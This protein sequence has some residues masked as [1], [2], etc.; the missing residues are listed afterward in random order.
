M[1]LI[2]CHVNILHSIKCGDYYIDGA[3]QYP[4]RQVMSFYNEAFPFDICGY[5]AKLIL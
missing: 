2:Y 3:S 5:Q 1:A 4:L